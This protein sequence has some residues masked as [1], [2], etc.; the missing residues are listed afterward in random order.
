MLAALGATDR[1]IAEF[2]DI[3]EKT[4]NRWK[5]EHPKFC[6]SIKEGKG[7][8]D[9]RVIRS[10]YNRAVGYSFP[11]EKLFCYEGDVTR[12]D[13]VEHVPPDVTAQIFWL[14]NRCRELWKDRHSTELS[15]PPGQ[16][17]EII[18]PRPSAE[19]LG[20]YFRR[21]EASAVERAAAARPG[22][23]VGEDGEGPEGE[24][25]PDAAGARAG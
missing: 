24:A 18:D 21:L 4:L 23:R 7:P 12:A 13:I 11:S 2:L 20:P 6:L 17:L 19:L 10:L 9:E 14:K 22:G 1:E 5:L 16:P 3:D 15:T 8:P 25:T